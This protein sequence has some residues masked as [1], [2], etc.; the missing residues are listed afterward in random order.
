MVTQVFGD[1]QVK[2]L[3]LSNYESHIFGT[4]NFLIS[5]SNQELSKEKI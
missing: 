1:S 3:K 4:Y 2:V 5:H